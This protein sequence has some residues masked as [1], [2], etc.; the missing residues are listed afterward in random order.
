M[1]VCLER[2][3]KN[4][5]MNEVKIINVFRRIAHYGEERNVKKLRGYTK[6][7]EKKEKKKKKSK[8]QKKRSLQ[9]EKNIKNTIMYKKQKH[10]IQYKWSENKIQTYYNINILKM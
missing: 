6:V 8:K 1:C 7:S 10:K 9:I 3:R 5:V 4:G 2:E